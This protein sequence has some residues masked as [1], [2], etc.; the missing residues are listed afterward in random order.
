MD[1]NIESK[2][3]KVAS[4]SENT[5]SFGLRGH[6]FIAED[7]EAWEAGANTVN[8]LKK[9]DTV[10]VFLDRSDEPDF[11]YLGFEIPRKLPDAPRN[12]VNEVW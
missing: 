1:V 2:Q 12:V 11:T 3:F 7:G 4:V 8:G 6:I 9:G 5:N 10:K